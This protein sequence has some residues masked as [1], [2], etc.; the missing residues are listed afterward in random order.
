MIKSFYRKVMHREEFQ[1]GWAGIVLTSCFLFRRGLARAVRRHAPKF[2][3]V[4]V[5]FGCGR[6]PYKDFFSVQEYIGVDVEMSGH[7]H[8]DEEIDVFYDGHVIPLPDASVD[9]ILCSEVFEHIFNLPE[10]LRE[11]HRI[12]KPGGLMLI[13]C[14]FCWNEHEV[15]FDYARYTRFALRHLLERAGFQI[16]TEEKQGHFIHALA[17]MG[18]VYAQEHL[19]P[20]LPIPRKLIG[21]GWN[22]LFNMLGLLLGAVLPK[23]W[24]FYLANVVLAKK[25]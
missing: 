18:L 4:M 10:I 19:R 16:L 1:P 25:V 8:H 2:S 22:S 11:L 23:R 21:F 5:D 20:R 9:N 17:Q 6:K 3:G 15:P 13:T 12:L 24:D 7:S 14:P